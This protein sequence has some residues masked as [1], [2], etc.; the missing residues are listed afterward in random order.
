MPISY[1]KAAQ[2]W[3]LENATEDEKEALINIAVNQLVEMF[4]EQAAQK[5]FEQAGIK[6]VP[7]LE[8]MDR[9]SMGKVQ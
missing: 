5:I 8:G 2:T 4:G 1:N 9:E 7:T 3:E 6:V